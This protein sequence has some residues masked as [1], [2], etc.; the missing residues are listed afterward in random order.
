MFLSLNILT[1]YCTCLNV[2]VKMP[3]PLQGRRAR[4]VQGYLHGHVATMTKFQRHTERCY[5]PKEVVPIY[6]LAFEYF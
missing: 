1:I 2:K 3:T 4:I 6:L 5:L